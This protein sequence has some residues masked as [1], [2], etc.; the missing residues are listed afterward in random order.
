MIQN[1]FNEVILHPPAE[2]TVN[3][4]TNGSLHFRCGPKGYLPLAELFERLSV[5]CRVY[6]D[7]YN[8]ALQTQAVQEAAGPATAAQDRIAQ[9]EAEIARLRGQ[10]MPVSVNT[11]PAAQMHPAHQLAAAVAT[12][13][14]VTVAAP[15]PSLLE[16]AAALA[17]RNVQHPVAAAAQMP[18]TTA[19]LPPPRPL[20]QP[21]LAPPV[22]QVNLANANPGPA[23]PGTSGINPRIAQLEQELEQ[24]RRL[25]VPVIHPPPAA[26]PAL[27]EG[28]V[29]I[30]VLQRLK[31]QAAQAGTASPD[32]PG[33][34]IS[35]G[36]EA[37]DG[38]LGP[39][40]ASI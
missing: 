4:W 30:P 31:E 16:V 39:P 12:K 18:V 25:G 26:A 27:P 36:R 6:A 35:G 5:Q 23:Q 38:E 17:S 20:P 21:V 34:I 32:A 9:M 33:T 7:A 40:P 13:S 8:T 37:D 22:Q 10:G 15:G 3:Q 28:T 1:G 24:L 14:P 19:P 11:N 29:H 2:I